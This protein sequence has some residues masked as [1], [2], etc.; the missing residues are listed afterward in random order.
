VVGPFLRNLSKVLRT[1]CEPLYVEPL[2]EL[3]YWRNPKPKF[4]AFFQVMAQVHSLWGLIFVGFHIRRW[5]CSYCRSGGVLL[6]VKQQN[7][8]G[9]CF[10]GIAKGAGVVDII[11]QFMTTQLFIG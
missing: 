7:T 9:R 1:I 4:L 11:N 3:L 5:C 8:W 2:R 6:K 10:R